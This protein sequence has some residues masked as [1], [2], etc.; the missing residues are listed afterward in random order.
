M[1][2]VYREFMSKSFK[3]RA[4]V[5]P[6]TKEDGVPKHPLQDYISHSCMVLSSR[7]MVQSATSC[8]DGS[9]SVTHLGSE[10][11]VFC[12]M[13]EEKCKCPFTEETI[14]ISHRIRLSH[15]Q[16]NAKYSVGRARYVGAFGTQDRLSI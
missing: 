9:I 4:F 1:L 2:G 7:K 15:C 5:F 13:N 14:L 10:P 12:E 11:V 3:S 16:T 6:L 8:H